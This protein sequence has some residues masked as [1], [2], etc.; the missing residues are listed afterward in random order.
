MNNQLNN[1]N[2]ILS[3][4]KMLNPWDTFYDY[5]L[6]DLT[7]QTLPWHIN[8]QELAQA[9]LPIIND[10]FTKRQKLLKSFTVRFCDGVSDV[11]A[12]YPLIVI[13]TKTDIKCVFLDSIWDNPQESDS[14]KD[15]FKQIQAQKLLFIATFDK[16]KL[17][18]FQHKFK[19][20]PFKPVLLL[21]EFEHRFCSVYAQKQLLDSRKAQYQ[22]FRHC[23]FFKESDFNQIKSMFVYQQFASFFVDL[24]KDSAHFTIQQVH[25]SIEKLLEP[26]KQIKPKWLTALFEDLK[27]AGESYSFLLLD[28]I[29]QVLLLGYG[30][31]IPEKNIKSTQ[32][33]DNSSTLDKYIEFAKKTLPLNKKDLS[34]TTEKTYRNIFYQE[35]QWDNSNPLQDSQNVLSTATKIAYCIENAFLKYLQTNEQ[36]L[37][38]LDLTVFLKKGEISSSIFAAFLSKAHYFQALE[39]WRSAY[40]NTGVQSIFVFFDDGF[41]DLLNMINQVYKT[42]HTSDNKPLLDSKDL[43][44]YSLSVAIANIIKD[45]HFIQQMLELKKE[46]YHNEVMQTV[47]SRD[48]ITIDGIDCSIL[49]IG[50]NTPD[51]PPD[52]NQQNISPCFLIFLNTAFSDDLIQ[53]FE[54]CVQHL[55]LQ[56][57]VQYSLP[58]ALNHIESN[59]L[60]VLN[61]FLQNN[62]LPDS[63]GGLKRFLVIDD[64]IQKKVLDFLEQQKQTTQTQTMARL[65][66]CI[67]DYDKNYLMQRVKYRPIGSED[68]CKLIKSSMESLLSNVYEIMTVDSVKYNEMV[69]KLSQASFNAESDYFN[70][71]PDDKF[72]ALYMYY[73]ELQNIQDATTEQE[74]KNSL[75]H[76]LKFIQYLLKGYLQ[77]P[78]FVLRN[79]GKQV[80]LSYELQTH[81]KGLLWDMYD[82]T[83]QIVLIFHQKL[84]LFGV[85]G[86]ETINVVSTL[87]SGQTDN[88]YTYLHR[89]VLY[90]LVKNKRL[91]FIKDGNMFID[92]YFL[93]KCE[94]FN[95]DE[96]QLPYQG[97]SD[98]DVCKVVD[99]EQLQHHLSPFFDFLPEIKDEIIVM[100]KQKAKN[101]LVDSVL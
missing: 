31:V 65:D 24:Y 90:N 20:S 87:V 10:K 6:D 60:G 77:I 37:Q 81:H 5:T 39:Q 80:C 99:L 22:I 53:S 89:D 92:G 50:K 1:I 42:L 15:Y 59:R 78:F 40:Q 54:S 96:K 4:K 66:N 48:K 34:D 35:I 9:L 58:F 52:V 69:R 62:V 75:S 44:L 88:Q 46:P 41:D 13:Q 18:Y 57:L 30:Q 95:V 76:I 26:V 16:H 61:H 14:I 23:V 91:E 45:V 98:D 38:S 68:V 47:L 63:L 93:V 8:N 28:V 43:T 27:N 56:G 12:L 85:L 7:N 49:N 3:A 94:D 79:E 82:N 86:F 64:K 84:P 101:Y 71:L 70:Q 33:V 72:K 21:S 32:T 19:Q 74:S 100:P 55:N 11:L 29:L 51:S 97:L 25:E 73:K 36:Q 83:Q 2:Q 67:F 17:A